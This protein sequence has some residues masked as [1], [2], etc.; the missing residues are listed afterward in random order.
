MRQGFDGLPDPYHTSSLIFSTS[1]SLLHSAPFEKSASTWAF[2]SCIDLILGFI[3]SPPPMLL[4]LPC[5]NDVVASAEQCIN[6][7]YSL[8]NSTTE[9]DKQTWCST[10]AKEHNIKQLCF[11]PGKDLSTLL[12][13]TG[14]AIMELLLSLKDCFGWS[15]NIGI[16]F[17]RSFPILEFD[18]PC[19]FIG[20][21]FSDSSLR[22][23]SCFLFSFSFLSLSFCNAC[24]R[25][26]FS[27]FF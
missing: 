19:I 14:L 3:M 21:N 20:S 8:S 13:T 22:D 2:C 25:F 10:K 5:N 24:S 27:C 6:I 12:C 23:S 1:C 17:T 9:E 7:I 16:E 18:L 15:E 4:K 26:S 11:S